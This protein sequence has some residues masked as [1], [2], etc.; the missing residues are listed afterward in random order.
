MRLG[1]SNTSYKVP[2]L[3][4][5]YTSDFTSDND[6]WD[7]TS[8]QGTLTQTYD[9][10]IPGGSGGGWMKNVYDTN[11]TSTSG[12]VESLTGLPTAKVGDHFYITY[13]LYLDGDWSGTDDVDV[14]TVSGPFGPNTTTRVSQDAETGIYRATSSAP[15]S[16]YS[17]FV[18]IKFD[19]DGDYPQSGAIFWIKDI[20]IK[21]YNITA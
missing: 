2:V 4:W 11:Q 5:E 18:Q 8:I 21:I 1:L 17:S 16:F 6:G 9:Q 14:L 13:K 15:F 19:T 10:D 3:R 12:L 20:N 7:P